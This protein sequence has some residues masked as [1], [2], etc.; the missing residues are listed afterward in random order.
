[1]QAACYPTTGPDS[2]TLTV[3]ELPAPGRGP[4]RCVRP[5]LVALGYLLVG[6]TGFQHLGNF[7]R[8]HLACLVFSEDA[9][10]ASIHRAARILD[11][12]ATGTRCAPGTG[13]AACSA[14]RC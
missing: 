5:F 6:F 1:M 3:R 8:L 4:A 2:G 10:E 14:R 9:V 7:N 12:W 13:C 11:Q